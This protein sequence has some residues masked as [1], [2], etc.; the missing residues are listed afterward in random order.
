MRAKN[1]STMTRKANRLVSPVE[2]GLPLLVQ[3]PL[4]QCP[5]HGDQN[6]FDDNRSYR[7]SAPRMT[8]SPVPTSAN[9]LTCP[10][11]LSGRCRSLIAAAGDRGSVRDMWQRLRQCRSCF[12]L[13]HH[14]LIA[15]AAEVLDSSKHTTRQRTADE[16]A[17]E[18]EK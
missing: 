14:H 18:L 15:A 13:V 5:R 6:T 8:T 10:C 16:A 1:K 9:S 2:T 4:Q 11:L 3:L 7:S 12:R 17:T